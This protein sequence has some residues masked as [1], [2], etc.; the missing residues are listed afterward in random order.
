MRLI[1]VVAGCSIFLIAGAA[2][3]DGAGLTIEVV[4]GDGA[5]INVRGRIPSPPR[6]RVLDENQRPVA[7]AAVTFRLPE[8]GPSARFE[9]G[10]ILTVTTGPAGEASPRGM[11]PNSQLGQW[12]IRVSAAHHGLLARAAIQQ[13]NAAP[14]EAIAAGKRSR[15]LYWLAAVTAGVAAATSLG[16]VRGNSAAAATLPGAINTPAA[17]GVPLNIT[18]GSST[19]SAP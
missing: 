14:V 7:G 8:A 9:D 12:E 18:A 11:R 3:T 6:V 10:R 5:V 1:G 19:I 16:V 13:I 17:P 4:E 2:R 15:T